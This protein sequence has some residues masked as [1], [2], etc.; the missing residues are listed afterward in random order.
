M[1]EVMFLL[2][3]LVWGVDSRIVPVGTEVSVGTQWWIRYFSRQQTCGV[4]ANYGPEL[5]GRCGPFNWKW[6]NEWL[7]WASHRSFITHEQTPSATKFDYVCF[8]TREYNSYSIG[9]CKSPRTV[10]YLLTNIIKCFACSCL[11]E[12]QSTA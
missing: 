12:R 3:H 5:T 8:S 11:I 6:L 1:N 7:M 2:F 9:A 4:A 10:N